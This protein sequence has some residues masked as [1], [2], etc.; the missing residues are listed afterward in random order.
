MTHEWREMIKLSEY[1]LRQL[2]SNDDAQV[3]LRAAWALG[4]KNAELADREVRKAALDEPSAGV[5]RHWVVML[6]GYGDF[7]PVKLFALEDP[8]AYVRATACQYLSRVHQKSGDFHDV[9]V[10]CCSDSEKRV[11]GACV[12]QLPKQ[13]IELLHRGLEDPEVE[14]RIAA[15]DRLLELEEG[16]PEVLQGQLS[17]ISVATVR[18]RWLRVWLQREGPNS[19]MEAMQHAPPIPVEDILH[20]LVD[21]GLRA[22]WSK[23]ATLLG[24]LSPSD[25]PLAAVA[26]DRATLDDAAR[27]WF[28]RKILETRGNIGWYEKAML[29]LAEQYFDAPADVEAAEIQLV[30]DVMG[31][32]RDFQWEP[33][34]AE[35]AAELAQERR[36]QQVHYDL[37]KELDLIEVDVAMEFRAATQ[38]VLEGPG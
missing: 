25:L 38:P 8:N 30:Q 27:R 15:G 1:E 17:E 31:I 29:L 33:V 18:Q 13:E 32:I 5:R 11:R 34:L 12:R 24:G 28:L 20:A 26:V 35:A 23:L 22:S 19:V 14:V 16:F 9:L 4:L 10:R 6:V 3:R 36:G 37:T 21:T 7:E 2:L